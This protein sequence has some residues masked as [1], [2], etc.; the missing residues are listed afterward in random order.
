MRSAARSTIC[1][2]RWCPV[3]SSGYAD[4]PVMAARKYRENVRH[5]CSGQARWVANFGGVA[6]NA[7]FNSV[8]RAAGQPGPLARLLRRRPHPHPFAGSARHRPRCC[9]SSPPQTW[10]APCRA[11][12]CPSSWHKAAMTRS[13]PAKR[14]SGSTT[15]YSSH[16]CPRPARS[17]SR[18]AST[19]WCRC[20]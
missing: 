4:R 2:A 14:H 8:P 11:S 17:L 16:A 12:T 18:F 3:C 1:D 6:T 5:G 7:N 9:P 15:H 20:G 13:R 19:R 10:F